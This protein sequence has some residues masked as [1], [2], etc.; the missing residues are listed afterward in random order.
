MYNDAFVVMLKQELPLEMSC[1]GY[2]AHYSLFYRHK[3]PEWRAVAML[4]SIFS[5]NDYILVFDLLATSSNFTHG[6]FLI[7]KLQSMHS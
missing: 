1:I 4:S 3:L 2:M 5:I 6:C 7:Y